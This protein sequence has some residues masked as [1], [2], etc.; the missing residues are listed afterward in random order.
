M[1]RKLL[2]T[3]NNLGSD[4]NGWLRLIAAGILGACGKWIWQQLTRVRRPNNGY[5][6]NAYV[7][8]EIKLMKE[9]ID[10]LSAEMEDSRNRLSHLESRRASAG[11]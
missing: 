7:V 3:D 8:S 9:S 11:D 10:R 1:Y 5:Y 4:P 2:M 6:S